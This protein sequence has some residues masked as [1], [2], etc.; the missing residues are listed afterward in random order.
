MKK[1]PKKT[2]HPWIGTAVICENV[3]EGKD[4]VM[5]AIRIVDTFT[6]TKP[7]EWDEATP[8]RIRLQG[9][10]ILRAGDVTGERTIRLIGTS[11]KRKRTKF[12]DF[13]V[14]FTGGAT[15]VNVHLD[16]I[17]SFKHDGVHWLDVYVEKWH[18]TRIPVTIIFRD[19]SSPSQDPQATNQEKQ[20]AK[21]S[22]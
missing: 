2:N 1:G 5:S 13:K 7:T 17:M 4:G 8:L 22:V 19:A 9:L 20:S 12:Y 14:T 15:N 11:P 10:L 3:L 18:A 21:A 6:V 16:F